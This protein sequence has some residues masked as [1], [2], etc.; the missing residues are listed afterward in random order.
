MLFSS[1]ENEELKF[2]YFFASA[3]TTKSNRANDKRIDF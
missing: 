1:N 2:P 3:T